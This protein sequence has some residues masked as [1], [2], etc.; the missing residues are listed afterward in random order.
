MTEAIVTALELLVVVGLLFM[1]W[2]AAELYRYRK[3]N[4]KD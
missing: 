1:G 4:D 3:N 2:I